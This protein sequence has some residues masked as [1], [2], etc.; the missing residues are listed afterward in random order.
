MLLPPSPLKNHI[1]GSAAESNYTFYEEDLIN[2]ITTFL[3]EK[4]DL[5]DIRYNIL[6]LLMHI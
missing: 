1:S 2:N 6:S 4:E 5:I 3:E